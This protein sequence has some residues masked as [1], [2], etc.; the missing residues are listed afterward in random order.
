[1]LFMSGDL[2]SDNIIELNAHTPTPDSVIERLDRFRSHVENITAVVTWD[3]GR[4]EVYSESKNMKQ[5][6]FELEMMRRFVKEQF[7]F[8]EEDD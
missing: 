4:T 7:D 8:V 1:M 6:A 5:L 2:V 3:D